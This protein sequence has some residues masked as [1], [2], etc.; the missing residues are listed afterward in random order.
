ML[1]WIVNFLSAGAFREYKT[2]EELF[3]VQP[4]E[5]ETF[6]MLEWSDEVLDKPVFPAWSVDGPTDKAKN[7]NAWG[8]D[9]SKWAKRAFYILGLVIHAIRRE[10]LIKVNARMKANRPA[11]DSGVSI[12]QVL[13]F[14]AQRNPKVLGNHY[15]SDLT[16]VDGTS[17]FLGMKLRTDLTEDFRTAKM[18]RNPDIGQSLPSNMREELQQRDEYVAITGEIEKLTD[19]IKTATD[20][21]D[22]TKLKD[23]RTAAYRR[24]AKLGKEELTNYRSNAK[25]VHPNQRKHQHKGEGYRGDGRGTHFDRIR[26]MMPERDRLA[27]SLFQEVPLRSP[28]GIA[29]IKDLIALRTQNSRVAYQ[30]ILRPVYHG[31]I[32]RCKTCSTEMESIRVAHRW[33]HVFRCQK[34]A[35]E[36]KHGHAEFCYLQ[37]CSKWIIGEAEWQH[38]CQNHINSGHLPFRCDPIKFRYAVA[39]AGYCPF[40]V[41]DKGASPEERMQKLTRIVIKA[42]G[43]RTP[44]AKYCPDEDGKATHDSSGEGDVYKVDCLLDKWSNWFFVRWFDGSCTWEPRENIRDNELIRKLNKEHGGLKWG[45]EV[46]QARRESRGIRYLVRWKGG[47]WKDQWIHERY[48]CRE[49]IEKHRPEKKVKRRRKN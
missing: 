24:R 34:R 13:K 48:M 12:G 37:T 42:P 16:T 27:T 22:L 28:E 32:A 49:L 46:R 5:G 41:G 21:K 7:H 8:N 36:T 17:C 23:E 45:V 1:W 39:C 44:G 4:P 2:I 20:D 19:K 33:N 26:H 15:L 30:E 38:H 10:I 47:K 35:L 29:V 43:T 14:A 11:L 31:K 6:W 18:K 3:S 40:H 25:R 9:V